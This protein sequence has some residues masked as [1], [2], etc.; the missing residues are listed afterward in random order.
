M[1]R[2]VFGRFFGLV[3]AWVLSCFSFCLIIINFLSSCSTGRSNFVSSTCITSFISPSVVLP[4]SPTVSLTGTWC[5]Q[6]IKSNVNAKLSHLAVEE[7]CAKLATPSANG[8][9]HKFSVRAFNYTKCCCILNNGLHSA[10]EQQRHEAERA[11]LC[12]HVDRD[13]CIK[14]WKTCRQQL[15]L[16]KHFT[17]QIKV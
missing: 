9:W 7:Q 4:S 2:C 1:D 10:R 17:Q 6:L 3:A 14:V 16:N 5:A 13:E 12:A 15:P 8:V 11:L